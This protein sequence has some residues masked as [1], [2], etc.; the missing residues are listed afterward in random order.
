M[1]AHTAQ[2]VARASQDDATASQ[3]DANAAA[4]SALEAADSARLAEAWAEYL[5]GI[6]PPENFPANAVTGDHWSSRWWAN[7][8]GEI[9]STAEEDIKQA[10]E[11]GLDAI[12]EAGEYWL[13]VIQ[14]QGESAV[15]ALQTLYLGAFPYP[16]THDSLG[17]P[18]VTGALYFDL[19]L[20]AAYVWN[21]TS[22]RPLV[23]PGP[24]AVIRYIYVAT[25]GQTVFTGPD[26][27]GNVFLYDAA[28]YQT[29]AVYHKGLLLTP[30]DDYSTSNNQVILT[31]PAAAGDIVQLR[32]ESVP[33]VEIIWNTARI[34]TA[35]WTSTGGNLRDPQGVA[36]KPNASSDVMLSLDGVWQQADLD[37]TVVGDVLTLTRP[38]DVGARTFGI[39]IV[40]SATTVVPAPGLKIIDTSGWVFDGVAVSFVLRDMSAAPVV[41]QTSANLMVSLNGVWQAAERDYTVTSSSVI[42]TVPPEVN[43]LV[44]AMAGLPAFMT[45]E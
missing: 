17:N 28:N 6:I 18:V 14:D 39:A 40:P 11:D 32:V 44:F 20:D 36:L 34:D 2:R 27:D 33:T 35:S 5:P 9:V 1:A 15:A 10:V 24:V 13:G 16:P 43:S 25:A 30:V 42:F 41:P 37:Y 12:N 31:A 3:N 7:R 45:T 26:R 8:A 38:M 4:E 29:V 22:W 19:T 21:G 23:T